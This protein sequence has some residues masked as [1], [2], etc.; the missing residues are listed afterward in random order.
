MSS[1]ILAD[2]TNN[3]QAS[4]AAWNINFQKRIKIATQAIAKTLSVTKLAKEYG[5]SRK[6]IYAQKGKAEIA[7]GQAFQTSDIDDQVLFYLPVTKAWLKQLVLALILICHSSY[8]GVIELFRDLFDY[9]ICKG[10][11]HNI[12]FSTLEKAS[13]INRQAD[14]SKVRI[15]AHDEIFQN[16]LPVLVGCDVF[17]TYTYLLKAEEFRDATTWGTHLLDLS[18]NQKLN[19]GH[20]IADAAKGLRKGQKEAWPDTPCNGDIFHALQEFSDVCR[21]L[22]KRALGSLKTVYDLERKVGYPRRLGLKERQ[23]EKD[24]IKKLEGAKK[25]SEKACQF[26]DDLTILYEW[27]RSDIFAVIGPPVDERKELFI[28]IIEQL[29]QRQEHHCAIRSLAIYL[30]NQLEDLLRFATLITKRLKDLANELQISPQIIEELYLLQATPFSDSERWEK[31]N[32]LRQKLR[33]QFYIAQEGVQTVLE[34]TIRASSVV[35]NLNSRLRNY[36]FLRKTLGNDYLTVLQFFLN[37]RRFLR[38]EHP[39]RV[40]KS[41]TEL[42]TGQ[43]HP[44]WLEMLDFKLFKQAA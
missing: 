16:R 10:T 42:L 26:F 41:P 39:Q 38:S 6:F 40:G 4:C 3:C 13:H 28:F 25:V 24:L 21:T 14:L 5:V 23:K 29:K 19:P 31:E 44:H 43:E 20:T 37:H 33:N 1:S 7:L 15:G 27:L 34:E 12:V 8:Q 36:F 30:E 11:I 18:K 9:S 2:Q 17:S 22:D 32:Q 35:E